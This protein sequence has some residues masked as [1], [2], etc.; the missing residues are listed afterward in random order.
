VFNGRHVAV[1]FDF[2]LD[3]HHF[4]FCLLRDMGDA[5]LSSFRRP[6]ERR[7]L[8]YRTTMS[9]H[10]T[11]SRTVVAGRTEMKVFNHGVEP[12]RVATAK[13]HNIETVRIQ[14]L[15]TPAPNK[16]HERYDKDHKTIEVYRPH[17]GE[18][19]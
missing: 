10:Y 7:A 1:D 18:G 2:G 13:G 16:P 11:V 6:D 12:M 3:W 5:H 15:H 14:D 9:N 4:N 19:H 17:W 8:F